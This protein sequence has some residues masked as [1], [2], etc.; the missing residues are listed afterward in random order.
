M[1]TGI[2]KVSGRDNEG[3]RAKLEMILSKIDM[4]F[5]HFL[6]ENRNHFPI[7]QSEI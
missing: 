7:T 3:T 2:G 4:D 1:W 6:R 5:E